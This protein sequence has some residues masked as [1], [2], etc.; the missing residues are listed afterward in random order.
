MTFHDIVDEFVHLQS[1]DACLKSNYSAL[2]LTSLQ[3]AES[4]ASTVNVNVCVCVSM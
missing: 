4:W 3:K 1:R 2:S